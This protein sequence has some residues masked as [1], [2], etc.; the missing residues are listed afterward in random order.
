MQ[1]TRFTEF[2]Y[3]KSGQCNMTDDDYAE[4]EAKYPHMEGSQLY[5]IAIDRGAPI[6]CH[7][8]GYY[9]LDDRFTFKIDDTGAIKVFT[10]TR[11]E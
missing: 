7:D 5:E 1:D 10:W 3:Y 6:S 2:D 11:N 8:K 4:Y 9:I